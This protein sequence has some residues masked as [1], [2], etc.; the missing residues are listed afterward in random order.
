MTPADESV[1]FVLQRGE[2]FVM[3]IIHSKSLRLCDAGW[4]LP[5]SHTSSMASILK[6][7]SGIRKGMRGRLLYLPSERHGAPFTQ[8]LEQWIQWN[9]ALSIQPAVYSPV[10]V[11]C[12]IN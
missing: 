1:S 5:G 7:V 2:A 10:L 4:T 11:K 6:T 9:G 12:F 8:N 3:L